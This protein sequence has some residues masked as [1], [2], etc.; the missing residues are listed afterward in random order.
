MSGQTSKQ[1]WPRLPIE[2]VFADQLGKEIR[3]ANQRCACEFTLRCFA[4]L[5]VDFYPWP[6]GFPGNQRIELTWKYTGY[7]LSNGPHQG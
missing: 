2:S 4:K 1:G 7:L 6:E 5:G 3:L